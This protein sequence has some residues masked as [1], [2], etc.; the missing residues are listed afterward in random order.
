MAFILRNNGIRYSPA[1]RRL[2]ELMAKSR[3]A[4]SSKALAQKLHGRAIVVGTANS[5]IEKSRRNREPFRIQ[6]TKRCGP[7]PIEYWVEK[8]A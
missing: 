6:K 4:V 3:N 7:H 1:E 5:L 2:F 8:R